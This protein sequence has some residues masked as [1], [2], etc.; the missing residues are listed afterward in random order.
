MDQTRERVDGNLRP[1]SLAIAE[2]DPATSLVHLAE[3]QAA[4]AAAQARHLQVLG[5][6]GVSGNGNSN[7]KRSQEQPRK[8]ARS[9]KR[10]TR[11]AGRD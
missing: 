7:R 6:S 3:A 5:T 8:A 9:D 1:A 2:V 4:P 11:A 10:I